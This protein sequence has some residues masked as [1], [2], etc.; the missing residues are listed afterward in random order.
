MLAKKAFPINAEETWGGRHRRDTQLMNNT[1]VVMRQTQ[2]NLSTA[3]AD[4]V[5]HLGCLELR[6]GRTGLP[7]LAAP[8]FEHNFA[9]CSTHFLAFFLT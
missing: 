5:S 8:S 4:T 1:Q 3:R 9:L 6:R 2:I 7:P